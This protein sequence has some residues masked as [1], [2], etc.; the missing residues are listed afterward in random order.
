[1]EGRSVYDGYED[2]RVEDLKAQFKDIGE[3]KPLD[4]DGPTLSAWAKNEKYAN[5]RA[6]GRAVFR[7]NCVSC[8]GDEA[9]GM[10]GPNLTDNKWKN[11]KVITDIP[12]V[13]TNGANN[14]AMPK[15]GGKLSPNEIAVVAAFV[16]S[17]REHPKEGGI[18]IAGE[19][20]IAPWPEPKVEAETQPA[21][22]PK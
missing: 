20:E 8:H 12:R 11:V 9:M 15:Q 6:I 4:V 1:M 18:H 5:Y 13:I 3:L 2:S 16:A 17:L 19:V 7:S 14:N 22:K 10:V 21:T